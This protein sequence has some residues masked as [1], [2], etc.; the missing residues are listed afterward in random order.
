MSDY[1]YSDDA[2]KLMTM[3]IFGDYIYATH[4]IDIE[5]LKEAIETLLERDQKI[6]WL[7]YQKC[8]TLVAI[9]KEF[10]VTKE[11]IRQIKARALRILRHPKFGIVKAK[12]AE[13]ERKKGRWQRRK[14]SDCWE[15]SECHA[16]LENSDIE[17]HNFYYCYHCGADM[18]GE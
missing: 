10:G 9:G 3:D 6:L 5:K 7:S 16:V 13:P 4:N 11:R 1:Q 2:L 18:R 14:G 15:C 8:E 12:T 17:N